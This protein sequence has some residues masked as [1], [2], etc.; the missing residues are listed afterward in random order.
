MDT[1][2]KDMPNPYT[3]RSNLVRNVYKLEFTAVSKNMVIFTKDQ[4]IDFEVQINQ[5]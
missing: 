1:K 5:E 2:D 4:T 3:V